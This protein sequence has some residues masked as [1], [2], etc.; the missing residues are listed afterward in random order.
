MLLPS[1]KKRI[2]NISQKPQLF[3]ALLPF[4]RHIMAGLSVNCYVGRLITLNASMTSTLSV[5]QNCKNSILFLCKEM[6]KMHNK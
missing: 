6:L 2:N 3:V 1:F 4:L 5:N